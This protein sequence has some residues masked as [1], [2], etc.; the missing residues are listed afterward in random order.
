MIPSA[1]METAGQLVGHHRRPW[2]AA[3]ARAGAIHASFPSLTVLLG[4]KVVPAS[5]K[6][7][8]L[9]PSL[10]RHRCY[11]SVGV[12]VCSFQ[13]SPRGLQGFPNWP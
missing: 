5:G 1:S 8:Q 6:V 13:G 10:T 2:L 11:V 4:A 12:V 9:L 3:R 7:Y